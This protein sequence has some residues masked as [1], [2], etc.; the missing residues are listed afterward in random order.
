MAR[1]ARGRREI[2]GASETT[3]TG[4]ASIGVID[5]GTLLV[6]SEAG[7]GPTFR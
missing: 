6:E 4:M 2:L 3:A 7:K 1:G 5:R